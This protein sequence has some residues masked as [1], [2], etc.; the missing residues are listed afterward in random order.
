[1]KPSTAALVTI[2]G[3]AAAALIGSSYG[4]QNPSIGRWYA[5][6][7]KPGY[8]PPGPV[9]GIVWS[10][11]DVLLCITGYRLLRTQPGAART[12]ALASWAANVAGLTGF[13]I[14]FF[15]RKKLGASASATSAL[16]ASASATVATSAQAD[17]VA[18]I[19]GTPL[20]LW[21]AFATLLSEE[22][23]RRN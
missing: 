18:A 13:P 2:G 22:I 1:M 16:F 5:K 9:F 8:T 4:P 3:V 15:G 20:L 7:R 21:T 17:P 6:L 23:W 19:A 14:L 11:L 12:V 10:C